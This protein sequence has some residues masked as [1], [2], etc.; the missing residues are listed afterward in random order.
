MPAAIKFNYQERIPKTRLCYLRE[1]PKVNIKRRRAVFLCDC[2]AEITTDLNWV[3]FLNIT[4]CGC[5][6]NEE[7]VKKNTKHSQATRRKKSGSY[8]SWQAMHQRVLVD[9]RYKNR[10][11][12][13]R[14]C[15]EKGFEN[16]YKD[17]GD[18]PKGLT[19]ERINNELGYEPSNCKWA[20]WTEQANNKTNTRRVK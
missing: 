1:A 13:S 18:R 4:S 11:I 16:F 19:I 5:Y 2:G 10:T 20:T 17:M 12:C 7:L 6:K 14:W 9:T 15:G 3:R 8:R